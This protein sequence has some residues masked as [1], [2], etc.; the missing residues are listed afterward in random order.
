MI[1]HINQAFLKSAATLFL[2]LISVHESIIVTIFVLIVVGIN[3]II[4][5]IFFIVVVVVSNCYYCYD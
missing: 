4:I 5:I 3:I 1:L 2:F